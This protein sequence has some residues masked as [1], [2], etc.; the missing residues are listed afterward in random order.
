MPFLKTENPGMEVFPMVNN[1][2][3]VDWVDISGFLNNPDARALFGAR[4]ASFCRRG[5]ITG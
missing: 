5:G 4:R 1:S 2:D 3:G